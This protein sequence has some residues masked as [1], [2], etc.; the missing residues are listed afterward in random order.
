VGDS[1]DG[2]LHRSLP[3]QSGPSSCP[4]L[5]SEAA[6][7]RGLCQG[8]LYPLLVFGALNRARASTLLNTWRRPCRSS[9]ARGAARRGRR[10]GRCAE[11]LPPGP[12]PC[13]ACLLQVLPPVL[14][15]FDAA[16]CAAVASLRYLWTG[17]DMRL[18]CWPDLTARVYDGGIH[19]GEFDS[20]ACCQGFYQL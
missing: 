11:V 7:S 17:N 14:A 13:L 1:D 2:H 20:E 16:G 3:V 4:F 18:P 10:S 6:A 8:C 5:L 19:C 12:P 15:A 9:G